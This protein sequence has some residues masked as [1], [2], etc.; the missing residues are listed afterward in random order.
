MDPEVF[1][2]ASNGMSV[3]LCTLMPR[4]F[5]NVWKAASDRHYMPRPAA[6]QLRRR[7]QLIVSRRSRKICV[8]VSQRR[9]QKI[10]PAVLLDVA[11]E[12]ELAS[13]VSVSHLWWTKPTNKSLGFCAIFQLLANPNPQSQQQPIR[14]QKSGNILLHATYRKHTPSIIFSKVTSYYTTISNRYTMPRAKKS[15][16]SKT[17]GKTKSPKAVASLP[18]IADVVLVHRH[19][20]AYDIGYVQI[21]NLT[22]DEVKKYPSR[23]H[24]HELLSQG[25]LL[26]GDRLEFNYDNEDWVVELSFGSKK[27]LFTA[28]STG[29]SPHLDI[30][31]KDCVSFQDLT[32]QLRIA[33]DPQPPK[34]YQG[35]S[36]AY[37]KFTVYRGGQQLENLGYVRSAYDIYRKNINAWKKRNDIR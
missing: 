17:S 36:I 37:A 5:I 1:I 2:P 6:L 13:G 22:Y 3:H 27:R 4:V 24:L 14:L 18:A 23:M 15:K 20:Q 34:D 11:V 7:C 29:T 28:K 26:P 33:Y 21:A 31:A 25:A 10:V 8:R 9:N 19:P 32:K 35:T 12:T 16:N 30:E